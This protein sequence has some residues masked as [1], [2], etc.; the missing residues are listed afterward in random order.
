MAYTA[1]INDKSRIDKLRTL[2][3]FRILLPRSTWTRAG[4]PRWS[5]KAYE[6]LHIYGQNVKATDGTTAAI[7]D[8]LPAPPGSG[9]VKAP[10][11]LKAGRPIRDE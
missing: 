10:R 1:S 7:K 6:F 9:D 11:E 2:G 5:E 4:Q 8:F 3:A